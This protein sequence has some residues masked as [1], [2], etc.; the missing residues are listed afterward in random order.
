MLQLGNVSKMSTRPIVTT[1]QCSTL[2][3]KSVLHSNRDFHSWVPG[4]IVFL[5]DGIG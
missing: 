5:L 3:S 4:K 2:V 1:W